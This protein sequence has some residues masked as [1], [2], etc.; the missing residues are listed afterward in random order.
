MKSV[1]IAYTILIVSLILIVMNSIV[2]NGI[3]TDTINEINSVNL[4]EKSELVKFRQIYSDFKKKETYISLTVNHEDLTS[5]DISFSEI[6]GA[7]S[8]EDID[9]VIMIKSRLIDSLFHLKRLSG[10]NIDSIF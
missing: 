4:N 1:K 9:S 6:I 8:A 3:I 2:L 5:I 10:I 7:S